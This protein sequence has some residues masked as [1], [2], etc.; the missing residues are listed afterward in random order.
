MGKIPHFRSVRCSNH[1]E[2][3]QI[4]SYF[5]RTAKKLALNVILWS[6]MKFPSRKYFCKWHLSSNEAEECHPPSSQ[7]WL[8]VNDNTKLTWSLIE[9]NLDWWMSF[10]TLF[11]LHV[12]S[13]VERATKTLGAVWIN[14]APHGNPPAENEDGWPAD[15]KH[16]RVKGRQSSHKRPLQTVSLS[17]WP[18]TNA[19]V[20]QVKWDKVFV[21]QE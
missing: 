11:F 13:S 3:V 21:W 8:T 5:K 7:S 15:E 10:Q 18:Q 2:V 1:W 4:V 16:S 17:V 9:T 6:N 14:A 20:L 12:F 19:A